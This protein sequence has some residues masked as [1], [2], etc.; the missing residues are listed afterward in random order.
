MAIHL[1]NADHIGI[2]GSSNPVPERES[3][4]SAAHIQLHL[5]EHRSLFL[6][7]IPDAVE[8]TPAC[9]WLLV[10]LESPFD[11]AINDGQRISTRMAL[12]PPG[13]EVCYFPEGGLQACCFLDVLCRD[14]RALSLR[15]QPVTDGLYCDAGTFADEVVESFR[16]LYH[17]PIDPAEF[18]DGFVDVLGLPSPMPEGRI[19]QAVAGVVSSVRLTAAANLTNGH[20][21]SEAGMADEVLIDNAKHPICQEYLKSVPSASKEYEEASDLLISDEHTLA[22]LHPSADELDRLSKRVS[23][24]DCAACPVMKT[25][26]ISLI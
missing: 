8:V 23:I 26:F 17:Q 4:A 1:G 3:S 15:M 19:Q 10:G 16:R 9:S 7:A 6:G 13:V 12:V 2:A 24:R 14:Y 11:I 18:Y 20:Y 25:A 5:W 21:A 22:S